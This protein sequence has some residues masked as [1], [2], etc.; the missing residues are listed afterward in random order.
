MEKFITA[1]EISKAYQVSYQ[2]INR[3]T[4]SGLLDVAFKKANIRYYRRQLV[5]SRMK[6]IQFFIKEGY[7]LFVIRK[8]LVG[9]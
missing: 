9:I 6:E 2:V 5:K 3:Y 8:K 4:D 1:K 7:P